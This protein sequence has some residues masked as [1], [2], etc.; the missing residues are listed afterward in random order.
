M[1]PRCAR[2]SPTLRLSSQ[3][4][5][6]PVKTRVFERT[7]RELSSTLRGQLTNGK[8]EELVS[9]LQ[10][11]GGSEW[12]QFASEDPS[13]SVKVRLLQVL[14]NSFLQNA[15]EDDYVPLD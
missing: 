14:A 7:V 8:S 1:W 13:R 10:R 6:M 15:I 5:A 2:C 12:Q 9:A 3:V 11:V 4:I